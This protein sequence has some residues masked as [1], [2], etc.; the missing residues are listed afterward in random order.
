MSTRNKNKS[1]TTEPSKKNVPIIDNTIAN[2][3][4]DPFFVK[5]ANSAKNILSKVGVPEL[6][7]TKAHT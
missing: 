3:E 6:L 7:R 2:Y 4:A 1:N 5:K